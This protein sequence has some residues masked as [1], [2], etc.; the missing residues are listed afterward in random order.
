MA[1][2]TAWGVNQRRKCWDVCVCVLVTMTPRYTI[3]TAAYG[4]AEKAFGG[5]FVVLMSA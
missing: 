2:W 3:K 5:C 4:R 1:G